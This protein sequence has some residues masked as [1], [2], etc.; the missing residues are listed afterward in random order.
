M[1]GME[2][3]L[4]D[5]LYA[6]T[7]LWIAGYLASMA[8]YFSGLN[9]DFWGKVV[10]LVYIPCTFVVTLRYFSGRD[11]T[12]PYY[13]LVGLA[14]SIIAVLL[15][16]PFIVLRFGAFQY[17]TPDVYLYY[18]AMFIIPVVVGVYRKLQARPAEPGQ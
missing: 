9:Y 16:Y 17:Y 1:N 4:R 18:A 12:L 3:I 2:Q 8:V 5:T 15:D 7:L 10:L 11:L 13:C 6:G 14:W